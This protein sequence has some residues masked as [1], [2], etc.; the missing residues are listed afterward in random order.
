MP[1]LRFVLKFAFS[2]ALSVTVS[3]VATYL[4][5]IRPMRRTW[6]VDPDESVKALPGDDLV[7]EA[8]LVETRGITVNAPP[9]AVWP[10]LVQ[11]GYGRG[12]WY[13]YDRMDND[14]A[15]SDRIMPEFQSLSV[16]DIMPTWPGGGFRV[17]AIDPDHSLALYLDTDLVKAQQ[18]AA[19]GAPPDETTAG[20]KAAGAMGG[21]AMPEFKASWTFVLEPL[22]GGRTRVIERMRAWAP[23]PS[24]AQ[25]LALPF[26]GL[27]V[28]LMTRK[29]L[30]GIKDRAER[31]NVVRIKVEPA[32]GPVA[33]AEAPNPA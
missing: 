13:S 25:K 11:M 1:V 3:L 31:A 32:A 30:L 14:A 2:L 8:A 20:L 27:G 15:S 6:G 16:G 18:A 7:P 33:Q 22:D 19:E 26:F 12:G 21:M 23:Q 4:T 9:S 17:A 5:V 28:F 10:W 29:Q 24:A